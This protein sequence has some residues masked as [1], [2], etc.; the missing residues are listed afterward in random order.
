MDSK[1]RDTLIQFMKFN[2]VGVIN[3]AIITSVY[4]FLIY[5]GTGYRIALT[6]DYTCGALLSFL[7]NKKITFNNKEPIGLEVIVKMI[8]SYCAVFLF[9]MTLL[10]LLIND[11]H[12]N[13]YLAQ[14]ISIM[15]IVVISFMFQ[16][17]I[18]FKKN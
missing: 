12:M 17:F 3:T 11:L 7:L 15:V 5:M 16:K 8:L 9:N 14:L 13:E 4:F 2:I 18:V 10:M 6:A 1:K